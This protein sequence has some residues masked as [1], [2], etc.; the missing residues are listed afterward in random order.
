TDVLER[1]SHPYTMALLRSRITMEAVRNRPLPALGGEPPSPRMRPSGCAF[2]VRC[3]FVEPRCREQS[4]QLVDVDGTM[5]QAACLRANE[6]GSGNGRLT[7]AA[8]EYHQIVDAGEAIL[9]LDN[10]SKAF[11]M[12]G[13]LGAGKSFAALHSVDLELREGECLGIVG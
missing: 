10:I 1:P 13:R 9:R 6:L 11:R 8:P 2:A 12:R 5:S 4:P 3:A 7:A